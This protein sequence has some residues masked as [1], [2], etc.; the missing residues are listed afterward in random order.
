MGSAPTIAPTSSPPAWSFYELLSGRRAFEG[1]SVR[2]D[3]CTRFWSWRQSRSPRSIAA[4]PGEVIQIVERALAKPKDERYQHVGDMLRDLSVYRLELTA[5]DSPAV[6]RRIPS[7][8]HLASQ[9]PTVHTPSQPVPLPTDRVEP[10][11]PAPQTAA[12]A[13]RV[14]TIPL[15]AGAAVLAI[16]AVAHLGEDGPATASGLSG[17]SCSGRGHRTAVSD[18]MQQALSA[19]EAEDYAAAERGARAVLARDPAHAVAQRLLERTR[20][21]AAT[22]SD[23]LKKA[24]AL[25]DQGKFEDASRVAGEVLSVAPGNADAKRLMADGAARSR[26]RGTEEARAQ[27][28]RAKAAAR[29]AGAHRLAPDAYA[30]ALAS[31][32]DA[33]RLAQAERQGDAT[34]KFY[35]ASGLFRSAEIAAQNQAAAREALARPA[36]APADKAAAPPADRNAARTRSGP[37]PTTQPV[38]GAAAGTP[39]T[40]RHSGR[41]AHD[42]PAAPRRTAAR[43]GTGVGASASA[44][45]PKP[46]ARPPNPEAEVTDLL[47]RYKSALEARDLGALQRIWPGLSGQPEAALRTEFGHATRISVEILDPRIVGVG[48]HRNGQFPA[49]LSRRHDRRTAAES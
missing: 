29:S 6:G 23:G 24:Q 9:M 16:A 33:E 45:L 3:A 31:E 47:A 20:T 22:V 35:E 21:A 38:H 42:P 46:P 14:P 13:R 43:A 18:V 11:T 26:R 37:P 7:D 19:F 10:N 44:R 48:Q 49:T 34:V 39:A 2:V 17:A 40:G 32:R 41:T 15:A 8:T 25:F 4:L 1:E 27:V 30:S 28:A 36:P 12:P 5:M